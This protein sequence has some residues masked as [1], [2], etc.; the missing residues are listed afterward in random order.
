M[1]KDIQGA[2]RDLDDFARD[3]FLLILSYVYPI[4]NGYGGTTFCNL[5]DRDCRNDIE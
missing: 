4:L 1:D 3:D 2:S 5:E